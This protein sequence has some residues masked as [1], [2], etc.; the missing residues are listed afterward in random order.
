[1]MKTATLLAALAMALGLAA[2]GGGGSGSTSTSSSTSPPATSPPPAAVA[3]KKSEA[4][5][6]AR[7]RRAAKPL[8]RHQ[9]PPPRLVRKAGS[10]APFLVPQG[11]NSVPTYGNEASTSALAA[12][13]AALAAFL[14]ARAHGDWSTA[15]RYLAHPTRANLERFAKGSGGKLSGCGTVLKTFSGSGSSA[16]P[17]T[18]GLLSLRVRGSNAFALF[19]GPKGQKYAMPMASEGGA[20]KVTQLAP[21][22]YPLGGQTQTSP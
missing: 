15:C 10:A 4:K 12:A 17:L 7:K 3:Q 1:M 18:Q 9:S 16:S 8:T 19:Y 20:W 13:E 21:I 22:A 2:C 6:P 11:D 14:D 5:P